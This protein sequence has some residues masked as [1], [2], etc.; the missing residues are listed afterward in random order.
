MKVTNYTYKHF[1]SI[2][3]S[4]V[5]LVGAAGT[6][7]QAQH[8]EPQGG[9]M[10]EQRGGEPHD[11][12]AHE[13]GGEG[14]HRHEQHQASASATHEAAADEGKIDIGSMI[15]G[16][17]TDGHHFHMSDAAVVP[18][19]C[20]VYNKE[21]GF[22]FF[23]SSVFQH[24]HASYNGYVLHHGVLNYVDSP[25]FPQQGSV[26]VGH[27]TE[28]KATK[29]TFV[30]YEGQELPISR[31][32]FFDLSITRTVFTMLLSALLM[33]LLFP[34]IAGGYKKSAVPTGIRNFFEVIVQFIRDDIAIPNLGDRYGKYMPY[35]LTVFFFI[36][37]NNLLGLIPFFPGGGNV[38]GNIAVT[39]TLA[40]ITFLITT[41][42]GNKNYWGH[43][44][45]PPGVPGAIKPMLVLIEFLSIFIKPFALA[46]RLFANI[47][48][49][50]III[51]SF[52]GIIFIVGNLAGNAA[53]FGVGLLSG[54]FM[55]ALNVLELFVA[56]LQAYIFTTLSAVF[57]GQA[58][59]EHHHEGEVAHH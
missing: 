32:A 5:L 1:L 44:F 13:Q 43:I 3:L 22:D 34:T 2:L 49:G 17:I 56:I 24:G 48:A 47:T 36:W 18:L 21:K 52:V 35:L 29:Q 20:I 46:L 28:D 4:V 14:H 8:G 12:H 59:E 40:V 37:F 31:A 10:H 57:I 15:M 26:H 55:I 27:M 58:I 39:A 53:G 9:H 23:M 7:V 11:G 19:P 50:H 41:F 30:S 42:S 33:L 6:K 38:M 16:H 25:N 45:N 54:A 51:L